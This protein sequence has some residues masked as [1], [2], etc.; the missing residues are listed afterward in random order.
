MKRISFM[1]VGV[2]VL[3]VL[4]SCAKKSSEPAYYI[5]ATIGN[6]EYYAADCIVFSSGGATII[7]SFKPTAKTAS[8]PHI[9]LNL[10]VSANVA[11]KTKLD[12]SR[13]SHGEYISNPSF[14]TISNSGELIITEVS[15]STISGTFSF[16]CEDGT[17]VTDGEFTAKRM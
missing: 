1:F 15:G 5:K 2:F 16:T 3:L 17:V 12:Y 13:G 9:A 11:G 10:Q 6:T 8:Y 14:K 4:G 7:N